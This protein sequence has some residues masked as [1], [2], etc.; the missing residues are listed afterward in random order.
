MSDQRKLPHQ[1]S[2]E[3]L[4]KAIEKDETVISQQDELIHYP[5]LQN[6]IVAFLSHYGIEP[7]DDLVPH[8]MLYY[9]Y[10]IWS[11]EPVSKRT[12]SLQV[13]KFLITH[14]KTYKIYY[15]LNKSS[16]NLTTEAF[17]LINAHSQNKAKSMPWRKHFE[18]FLAKYDIKPGNF[19][20]EGYILYDLYDEYSYNLKRKKSIGEQQFFNFCKVYFK[21]KYT[22]TQTTL[23]GIDASIEKTLTQQRI[24]SLR[25]QRILRHGKK[26]KQAK[27]RKI[28][29]PKTSS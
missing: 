8:T 25:K 2:V 9:L 5:L 12:F 11:K 29:S 6:D 26:T 22:K 13:G 1:A 4:L 27:Q 10:N 24:A 14:K 28:S 15:M 7:G 18:N 23:F 19:F 3:D 16:L 20:L 21:S 17:K